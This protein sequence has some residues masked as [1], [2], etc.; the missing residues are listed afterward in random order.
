MIKV[1][2]PRVNDIKGRPIYDVLM[3]DIDPVDRPF[4]TEYNGLKGLLPVYLPDHF[5]YWLLGQNISYRLKNE[6]SP[7]FEENDNSNKWYI[8]FDKES[9][10]ILFKLTWY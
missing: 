6:C 5:H 10:A 1:L 3:E 4:L 2:I 7:I 9:D 8:V